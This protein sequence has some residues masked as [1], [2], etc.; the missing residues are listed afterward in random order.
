MKT[1]LISLL[2]LSLTNIA[3]AGNSVIINQVT[4]G[5]SNNITVDV[6]GNDNEIN[7]SHGG[8]NNTIN[9]TQEG[10]DGYVGYTSAW[11]SG[12][13]W[14]G[15]LDGN[16]N[17]LLVKQLCNQSTCGGD[18]F[19]FHIKGDSNDVEFY[20]G[21]TVTAGGVASSDTV[22]HGGHSMI[23]DIH[24]SSNTFLGSQRSNNSG[25]EHSMVTY[26][27]GDSNDIYMRQDSNV[28]KTMNLTVN[29]DGNDIDMIQTGNSA[30]SAT[31]TVSGSYSTNLYLKQQSGTAQSYSLTQ[32]C[33][34]N[35]GCSVSVTQ[36]N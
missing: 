34:T 17:S 6:D 20:Q 16:S 25:H 7:M 4:S 5:N 21:Y 2:L 24:G 30:H 3:F 33:Q 26:I 22:E 15:D 36:G 27:Y 31:V 11:G 19:E 10:K 13:S 32:N 12:A 18:R 8:G 1:L 28:S 35:G 29:N 9:I 14:G 23:L